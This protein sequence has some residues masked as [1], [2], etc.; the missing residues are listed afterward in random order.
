M[1]NFAVRLSSDLFMP[2]FS[3]E[4]FSCV[5]L[6]TLFYVRMLTWGEVA[7]RN[8]HAQ[9]KRRHLLM[10]I[11]NRRKNR[12]AIYFREEKFSNIS[13]NTLKAA[14]RTVITERGD[15]EKNE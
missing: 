1:V 14:V 5:L 13:Y 11:I 9:F 10:R 12:S 6:R 15:E 4:V 8:T 7:S 3:S 2:A